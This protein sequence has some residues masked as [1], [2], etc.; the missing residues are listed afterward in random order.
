M[1]DSQS[2]AAAKAFFERVQ[3]R[4]KHL[5]WSDEQLVKFAND[6]L[7]PLDPYKRLKITTLDFLSRLSPDWQKRLLI[8]MGAKV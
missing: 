7:A 2:I 4:Q 3:A 5:S 8:E 6:K 1:A